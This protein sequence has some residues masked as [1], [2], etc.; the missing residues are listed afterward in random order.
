MT[1]NTSAA[2]AEVDG[3]TGELES[4]N[5]LDL[6]EAETEDLD[7]ETLNAFEMIRADQI[8]ISWMQDHRAGRLNAGDA[9]DGDLPDRPT[10]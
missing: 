4:G 6:A 7:L 2:T 3:S 1:R 9:E 10:R 5:D 8:R